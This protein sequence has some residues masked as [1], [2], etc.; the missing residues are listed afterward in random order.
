M[1]IL[2]A[3]SEKLEY[4]RNSCGSII[5]QTSAKPEPIAPS[6]QGGDKKMIRHL[7]S[8]PNP[9]RS[10]HTVFALLALALPGVL[11]AQKREDI[12]SIQRDVAQL[13]DQL[14]QMQASQDQ[15]MDAI[16]ALV[17]QALEESAKLS[18]ALAAMQ[19]NVGGQLADQ[20]AKVVAPVA[21]LGTKVDELSNDTRAV[22]EN[23][24]DLATRLG[25]LDNKLEDISSAIRTLN[26]P[27]VAPPP[28]A[29]GAAQ[30]P[31]PP[32]GVSADSLWQNA[33]RDK[34]SGKDEL[35][36]KEF[37]DFVKYFPQSENAPIAQY[38]IGDLYDRAKQYEDAVQAFDAVLERYAENP[39]TPDA[40][41]MK[42]VD[43]MKAG[44]RTDAATEFK[45]FLERYPGH[46]LAPKAQLH[47]K[48]LGLSTSPRPAASRAKKK[49]N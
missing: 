10:R 17:K 11:S 45:D 12:L 21:T 27:P 6:R 30:T 2:G 4:V 32:P 19:K 23:V 34:S 16:Q 8:S 36:M 41:Y 26:T 7:S 20:Q 44:R 9:N 14:K 48:E 46:S 15:K 1:R 31:A 49:A 40:L 24:A 22:R 39:R 35:A 29:N 18:A 3:M 25:K 13:Q 38:Y 43:L 47:L 33:L 42:G 5:R 28:P 37:S